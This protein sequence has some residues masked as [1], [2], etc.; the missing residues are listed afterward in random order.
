MWMKLRLHDIHV[1]TMTECEFRENL[2]DESHA[3]PGVS[4]DI[5][6]AFYTFLALFG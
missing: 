1:I 4:E 2:C 6:P 3:L 5:F